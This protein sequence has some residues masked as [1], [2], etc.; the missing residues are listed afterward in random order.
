MWIYDS[1]VEAA[2]WLYENT[3]ERFSIVTDWGN[4]PIGIFGFVTEDKVE[5]VSWWDGLFLNG[6]QH[7]DRYIFLRHANLESGLLYSKGVR[8]ET[9][10]LSEYSSILER[11]NKIYA[12]GA[13]VYL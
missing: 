3:N 7:K 10:N 9:L 13:E 5:R 11:R 4:P 2:G 1:E 8:G 6:E 12:G